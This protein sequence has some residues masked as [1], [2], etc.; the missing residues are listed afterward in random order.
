MLSVRDSPLSGANISLAESPYKILGRT[1]D[2]GYFVVDAFCFEK[3]KSI[4][5]TRRG[6]VPQVVDIRTNSKSALKIK[7]ETAGMYVF[8]MVMG[9]DFLIE[10]LALNENAGC[11]IQA[12]PN[13]DRIARELE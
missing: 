9:R 11:C 7:M 12:L 3:G 8:P 5:I 2:N 6:Y 10:R 4:L 13:K 1:Q